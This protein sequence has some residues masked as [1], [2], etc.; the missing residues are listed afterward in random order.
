MP[1]LRLR[2]VDLFPF[3]RRRAESRSGVARWSFF[4]RFGAGG[5]L[6]RM[7]L[8]RARVCAKSSGAGWVMRR[9]S[10][11]LVACSLR[12]APVSS[13]SRRFKSSIL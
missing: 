4:L 3:F 11:S 7:V 8:L 5:V 10:D 2:A 13:R 1:H 9:R 6:E 12:N